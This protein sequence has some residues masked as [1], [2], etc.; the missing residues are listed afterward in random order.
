LSYKKIEKKKQSKLKKM[1]LSS[2]DGAIRGAL[3]GCISNGAIAAF[4]GA[5][6]WMLINGILN[7]VNEHINWN[8]DI[9][10]QS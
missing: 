3:T 4:D 1:L 5:L 10:D 8:I 6:L 9:I 7:G 2:R